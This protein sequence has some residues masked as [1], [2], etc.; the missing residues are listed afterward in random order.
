MTKLDICENFTNGLAAVRLTLEDIRTN[1]K[2][3]GGSRGRHDNYNK[4]CYRESQRPMRQD[5][6]ICKK[7]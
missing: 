6:C 5:K 2:Y 1:W 7:G 4:T 3:A